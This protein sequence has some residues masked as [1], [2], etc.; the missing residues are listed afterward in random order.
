MGGEYHGPLAFVLHGLM[1]PAVWLSF[2]GVAV[3]WFLYMKRPDLPAAIKERFSGLYNILDKKY[4]FDD[5]NDT[6]FAGGS[7]GVGRAFWRMGD[8]K[9]ISSARRPTARRSASAGLPR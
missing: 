8:V 1:A 3:A 5:F 9:L 7:R 2:A 6:V 4:G